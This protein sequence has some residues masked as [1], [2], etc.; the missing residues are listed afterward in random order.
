MKIVFFGDIVGRPGRSA[1]RKVIPEIK[2]KYNPDVIICNGENLAHGKGI[3]EKTVRSIIDAGVDV[4]TSGNHIFKK[5]GVEILEQGKLPVIRPAN[6]PPDVPGNGFM[7]LNIGT[8]K[9]LVINVIGQA[10]FGEDFDS[11]FR[12]LDEILDSKEA[13]SANAIFVDAHTEVTSEIKGLGY[14][15]DGR[16]TACIGTHTHIPT[17][18]SRILKKDTAYLSDAGMVG[19][20][21]SV[22]GVGKEE[23]LAKFLTQ[24]PA[25]FQIEDH[26][27]CEVSGVYIE[28]KEGSIKA[29]KIESIYEEVEV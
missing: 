27:V 14:Y 13:S 3:T 2:E 6:Y 19:I 29:K 16:V 15:L 23:V 8:E 5:E 20:K 24:M 28:S 10:F 7:T 4:I 18:D 1:L 21:D 9:L 25:K 17:A 12:K 11:P 26:G 22:L